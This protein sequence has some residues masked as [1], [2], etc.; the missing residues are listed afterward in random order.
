MNRKTIVR[1]IL[2]FF[3]F[4]L[5]IKILGFVRSVIMARIF[6]A[7]AMTDAFYL[8]LSAIFI[9][10]SIL[11]GAITRIMIPTLSEAETFDGRKQKY[12]TLNNIINLFLIVSVFLVG[13]L[14]A[15]AP[16][17][18]RLLSSATYGREQLALATR[19]FRI[20]VPTVLFYNVASI[21]R[22]YLQSEMKFL[23]SSMSLMPV[24]VIY[25]IYL[26]T[27]ADRF[28]LEGL[29]VAEVLGFVC[30]LLI[31]WYPLRKTGYR[32]RPKLVRHDPY[33]RKLFSNIVPMYLAVAATDFNYIVDKKLAS[34]LDAG[35]ISAL[36]ISSSL[37]TTVSVLFI[38]AITVVMFPVITKAMHEQREEACRQL[39]RT[40]VRY[41][42][43]IALPL[44]LG[45]FVFAAPLVRLIYYGGAFD[46]VATRM[47][48]DA[49][50]YYS[51]GLFPQAIVAFFIQLL[52]AANKQ[53]K[54]MVSS[55]IN[56]G[57]NVVLSLALMQ[58]MAHAGLALA[59]TLAATLTVIYL[60]VQIH[61]FTGYRIEREQVGFLLKILLASGL[62]V[63]LAFGIFTGLQASGLLPIAHPRVHLLCDVL[64]AGGVAI[65]AYIVGLKLL[66]VSELTSVLRMIT[67]KFRR[68]KTGTV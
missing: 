46:T 41:V 18:I 40:T 44:G 68:G 26:W 47:T 55:F 27:A 64:I 59:T 67:S 43:I 36:S 24:N 3:I 11:G 15:L 22:G 10:S 32:Y 17:L 16:H 52:Y 4:G 50:R 6:G 14:Y 12:R 65:G 48:A 29:M 38:S 8:A 20:G 51:I 19:L 54:N 30:Q 57:V 56:L 37:N 23:E 53:T 7:N 9:F 2:E 63:G 33:V 5:G 34:R 61:A 42:A 25:L 28:G 39:I 49:L 31:Q 58:I 66:K 1:S 21:Y 60:R 45:M 62:M 13:L 35:S